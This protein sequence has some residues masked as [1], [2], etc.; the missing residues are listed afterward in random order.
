MTRLHAA[1]LVRLRGALQEQIDQR[2]L[3]GAVAVVAQ[4]GEIAL[5]EAL[6][7]RDAAS[8]DPMRSD[9]VFRIYSMT[10]PLVSLAAL[11][12]VEEGQLQLSDPVARILPMF[13]GLTVAVEEPGPDGAAPRTVPALREPTVHDLLRHTAGF[14]YEF[15]GQSAVQ[16]QYAALDIADRSRSNLAF[17]E[18]LAGIPLAYQPGSCWAYSRA[19]DVL[20]ALLEVVTGQTLGRLLRERILGPLGMKDTGF[21]LPPAQWSRLAE[22]FAQCP[23]TG[24]AVR[25]IDAREVPAL[26]SGG[27]GLLSTAADYLRFLQLLRGRGSFDGVRLVSAST[28]AWMTA[29][30]LGAIPARGDLLA[31]GHGFS[32]GFGVRTHAGLAPQPGSPGTF[33]WSGIGGTSFFVDPAQDLFALLLTQAPNQRLFFRRLFQQ[34]VYAALD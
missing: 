17:C 21:S 33:H 2:R 23:E 1:S 14:T 8:A 7:W 18:V 31:P 30:H 26:E 34:M 29:D 13:A 19:T 15:L 24:Q 6:G 22:P 11:M 10:K 27:G 28:F 16:R 5:F 4:G 25:L 9:A 12:L 32:L 20:G 3:P